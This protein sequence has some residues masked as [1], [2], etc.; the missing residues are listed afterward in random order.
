MIEFIGGKATVKVSQF[1]EA[2]EK[3]GFPWA[4]H[5]M[6]NHTGASCAVG[7][8]TRNLFGDSVEGYAYQLVD[9][10][11]RLGHTDGDLN[12]HYGHRIVQKNDSNDTTNYQE[13]VDFTKKLLA[14]LMDKEI[15]VRNYAYEDNTNED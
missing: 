3:N 11:D 14:P 12:I 7:Q 9:G 6:L 5:A 15:V 1:V 10:L 13:V 2:M 8:A 4:K